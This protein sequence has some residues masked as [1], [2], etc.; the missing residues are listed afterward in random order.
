MGATIFGKVHNKNCC[1]SGTGCCV[2]IDMP[3]TL[4]ATISVIGASPG[5]GCHCLPIVVTM[6]FDGAPFN[7]SWRGVVDT[8]PGNGSW[9]DNSPPG[10]EVRVRFFCDGANWN[11][12]FGAGDFHT[13]DTEYI[14]APCA[15]NIASPDSFTCN[16]ISIRFEQDGTCCGP[17]GAPPQTIVITVTE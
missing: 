17:T 2:G 9:C 5:G 13:G 6:T 8:V 7:P 4:Y 3:T 15:G 14:P 16:P 10:T 12:H 11:L 1:C